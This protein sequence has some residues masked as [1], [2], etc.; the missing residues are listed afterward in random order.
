MKDFEVNSYN[1]VFFFKS[2]TIITIGLIIV[3]RKTLDINNRIEGFKSLSKKKKEV[4]V[5]TNICQQRE[6]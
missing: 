4:K 5:K 2:K 3:K 6:Y 1:M